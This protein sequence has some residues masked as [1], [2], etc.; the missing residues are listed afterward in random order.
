MKKKLL[1]TFSL[2]TSILFPLLLV[3]VVL[4]LGSIYSYTDQEKGIGIAISGIPLL[5]FLLRTRRAEQKLDSSS[6]SLMQSEARF[7]ALVESSSGWIWEV[8]ANGHYVYASPKIKELL[9]Y[10]ADKIIGITPF[11]LMDEEEAERIAEE[12][13][14][15]VKERR[16]FASME[17]VYRHKDGRIVIVETS[18]VPIIDEEGTLTG[19]HGIHRD[20]TERKFAE[21]ALEK[22]TERLILHFQ[23][24]PLAIIEWGIDFKVKEWN[25]AAERIFGYTQ[26]EAIGQTPTD[27]IL[28]ENVKKQVSKI[29]GA[30]LSKEG[31]K[32]STNK[33]VTKKGNIITCEWYN[34]PLVNKEGQ[35]IGVASMAED[36]TEQKRSEERITYMAYYD[37]LTG[38]PNRTLFKDRLEQNCRTADR[39]KHF[40]GVLFMGMD[41]FK[42]INDT[43]GHRVGDLLLQAVAIRLKESFRASDT[44]SSFGGDKFAVII[45]ELA[46]VEEIEHA[47]RTVINR[48]SVPFTIMQHELF[49][50]LSVGFSYYPLDDSNTNN[51]LR[52]ADTAM[53]R[54]KELGGNQY[55]QYNVEMT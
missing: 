30:L 48:F 38:L 27:L 33:N 25:P 54:V 52:N 9:G 47:I 26:A 43:L 42:G 29:W 23:Q 16:P 13:T 1:E 18:G 4:M 14:A 15:I 55:Q 21:E 53:H 10:E 6:K 44:V 39:Y 22:A 12:F 50:T 5:F 34:T 19:Y 32:R 45:P 31:G 37:A 28:P 8:D 51:L 20:I 49:V 3:L 40:V 2:K 17:N 36:V 11:E 7:R 46:H 35:V 41:Q 24:S